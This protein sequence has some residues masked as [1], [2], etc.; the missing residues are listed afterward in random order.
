MFIFHGQT[1][2][3]IYSSLRFALPGS[4]NG[5]T[6]N[7]LHPTPL[8]HWH[9]QGANYVVWGKTNKWIFL[10]DMFDVICEH[11]L[12][13]FLSWWKMESRFI[14][15]RFECQSKLA[16]NKSQTWVRGYSLY[17]KA[18][19][20]LP[21]AERQPY[22]QGQWRTNPPMNTFPV[23]LYVKT[24]NLRRGGQNWTCV[25]RTSYSSFCSRKEQVVPFNSV[26][27]CSLDME[28]A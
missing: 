12:L 22:S 21:L 4:R 28:I 13:L 26:R 17:K 16:K 20:F 7:R 24:Q 10:F 18:R 5:L 27:W 3:D 25:R 14:K 6:T 1:P 8:S 23:T 11:F 15:Q 2:T 19:S 9:M